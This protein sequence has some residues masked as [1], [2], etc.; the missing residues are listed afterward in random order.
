MSSSHRLLF[1]A[2]PVVPGGRRLQLRVRQQLLSSVKVCV[3][4]RGGVKKCQLH[5][6][7]ITQPETQVKQL[8]CMYY[9]Y[10]QPLNKSTIIYCH[11]FIPNVSICM[12]KYVQC[13]AIHESR[14]CLPCNA[15]PIIILLFGTSCLQCNY[16]NRIV[17]MYIADSS[18]CS[19]LL[20]WTVECEVYPVLV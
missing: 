10:K 8:V 5:A 1:S 20:Q 2:G 3:C 17:Y 12:V 14:E 7:I 11:N 13:M 4:G 6:I 9:N 16:D 15:K 18:V 19:P